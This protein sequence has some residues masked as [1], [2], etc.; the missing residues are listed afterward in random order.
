MLPILVSSWFHQIRIVQQGQIEK[1]EMRWQ[2]ALHFW[3]PILRRGALTFK[4]LPGKAVSGKGTG[5]ICLEKKLKY[6]IV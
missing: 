3:L 6:Q 4:Q 5:E 2:G 1:H